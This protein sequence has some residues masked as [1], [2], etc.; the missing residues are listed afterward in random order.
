M[1]SKQ[2]LA[3]M[4]AATTLW[5]NVVA[6]GLLLFPLGIDPEV[7]RSVLIGVVVLD[8]ITGFLAFLFMKGE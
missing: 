5:L 3:G 8:G 4:G 2:K 1:L 6:L 7:V